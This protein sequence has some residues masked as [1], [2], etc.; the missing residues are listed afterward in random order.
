MAT[1]RS[2]LRSFQGLIESIPNMLIRDDISSRFV[3]FWARLVWACRCRF[4]I[5]PTFVCAVAARP[6]LCF[7][8]DRGCMHMH[9]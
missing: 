4:V 2:T 1:A 5:V 9:M 8:G 6:L 7:W 3:L